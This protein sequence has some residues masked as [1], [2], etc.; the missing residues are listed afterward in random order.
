MERSPAQPCVHAARAAWLAM[1]MAIRY[2]CSLRVVPVIY[3][4]S[5]LLRLAVAG[6]LLHVWQCGLNLAYVIAR[7]VAIAPLPAALRRARVLRRALPMPDALRC[8]H[9]QRAWQ[10]CSLRSCGMLAGCRGCHGNT[11]RHLSLHATLLFRHVPECMKG[12]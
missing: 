12:V 6:L 5:A 4:Y 3:Y 1:T 2:L 10:P 11:I 8:T 7:R 9:Q